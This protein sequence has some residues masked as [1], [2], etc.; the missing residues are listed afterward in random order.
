MWKNDKWKDVGLS[1]TA[2]SE[3]LRGAADSCHWSKMKAMYQG[4]ERPC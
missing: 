3:Q 4:V 1:D 2:A